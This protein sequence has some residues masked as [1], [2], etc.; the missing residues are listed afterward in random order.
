LRLPFAISRLSLAP[1]ALVP[2]PID[3]FPS[4]FQLIQCTFISRF[5]YGVAIFFYLW[6]AIAGT[7]AKIYRRREWAL[8]AIE[9]AKQQEQRQAQMQGQHVVATVSVPA[10]AVPMPQHQYQQQGQPMPVQYGVGVGAR[11]QMQVM[12]A[13]R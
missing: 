5:F 6:M 8:V 1:S 9:A 12:G 10:Y 13:Y 11:V 3:S 4:P 7:L 2:N